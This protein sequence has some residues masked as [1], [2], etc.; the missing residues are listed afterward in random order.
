M[1]LNKFE[2]EERATSGLALCIT[3]LFFFWS[4]TQSSKN[5][6]SALVN[7]FS[8]TFTLILIPNKWS[9]TFL[10]DLP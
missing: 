4:D 5:G 10:D 7:D 6:F 9:Q 2:L 3:R 8:S 1:N